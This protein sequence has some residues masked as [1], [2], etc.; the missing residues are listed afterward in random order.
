[1][2][3]RGDPPGYALDP[4]IANRGDFFQTLIAN[5]SDGI[6]TITDESTIVFANAGIERILGWHPEELI[7]TSKLELIPSRLR[8]DHEVGLERYLGGGDRN[9]D[10]D[11]VELPALHRDGHEVVVSVTLCEHDLDGRRLFSGIFR[12]VTEREERKRELETQNERL[13]QFAS[14]LS[15]DLRN[16][17]NVAQAYTDQLAARTTHEELGEITFAL[18]RMGTLIDELLALTQQ[19]ETI[20][21][22]ESVFPGVVALESWEWVDTADAQL[23]IDDDLGTIT[24]DRTRF[25]ELFE[26][27]F[28]NAIEHGG[29]DVTV[30]V[31]ALAGEDG[32]FVADDG[33]GVAREDRTAIFE[34]GYTTSPDGT[35]LGLAIV[36][37]IADAHGWTVRLADR[38]GG[39]RFEFVV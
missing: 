21:A 30:T 36:D 15:H 23:V 6:L 12:D 4:T 35:G 22:V 31:G 8:A 7:G 27:L 39:A 9:I 29:P 3:E 2:D 1:M 26:N 17:L 5:S 24:A 11:G 10:W 37:R 16:P 32:F 18:E 14:V 34:Q 28:R 19:G 33:R 25:H 13:A 20:G 38:D